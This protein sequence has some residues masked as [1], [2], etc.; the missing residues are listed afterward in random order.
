VI[1]IGG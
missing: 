1:S